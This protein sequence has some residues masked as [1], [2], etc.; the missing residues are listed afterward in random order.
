[1]ES[2]ER[3]FVEGGG[4]FV[5]RKTF[6]SGGAAT[7]LE[8]EKLV[9][10]NCNI[11]KISFIIPSGCAQLC[12]FGLYRKASKLFPLNPDEW[13]DGHNSFPEFDT[14]LDVDSGEEWSLRG[15]NSDDTYDHTITCWLYARTQRKK[16]LEDLILDLTDA[17]RELSSGLSGFVE[18]FKTPEAPEK[19]ELEA[20]SQEAEEIEPD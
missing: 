8:S 15:Y 18:G 5:I 14:D 9:M 16:R 6:S 1:M 20:E 12:K 17:V 7:S 4:P 13:L 19:T 10:P 11:Y 2:P 3:D